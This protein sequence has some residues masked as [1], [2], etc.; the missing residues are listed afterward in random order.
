LLGSSRGAVCRLEELFIE[1][2]LHRF[3]SVDITPQ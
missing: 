1:D 2:D 3:H